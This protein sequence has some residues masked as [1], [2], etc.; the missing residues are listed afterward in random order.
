MKEN[1]KDKP[2]ARLEN[3]TSYIHNYF[4]YYVLRAGEVPGR[5]KPESTARSATGKAL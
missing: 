5:E 2:Y 1:N 3:Y 4:I